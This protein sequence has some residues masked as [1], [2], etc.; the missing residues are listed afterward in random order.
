MG[1]PFRPRT[2]FPAGPAGWKAGCGQDCS[3]HRAAKPQPK[4]VE[5]AVLRATPAVMPAYSAGETA[6]MA[7]LADCST[8]ENRRRLARF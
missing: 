8:A 5:R 4:P 6:G 2:R 1:R 3:P 7:V